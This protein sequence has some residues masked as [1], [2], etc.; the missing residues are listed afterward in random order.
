M[1]PVESNWLKD[2]LNKKFV[3]CDDV[4]GEKMRREPPRERGALVLSRQENGRFL[5]QRCIT[6]Q[7]PLPHT[8]SPPPFPARRTRLSPHN[9]LRDEKRTRGNGPVSE[10]V[11]CGQ[12]KVNGGYVTTGRLPPQ[13]CMSNSPRKRGGS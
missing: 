8:S 13:K 3:V 5:A 9:S 11:S 2:G 10:P 7:G 12:Q 1:L 4:D 6:H